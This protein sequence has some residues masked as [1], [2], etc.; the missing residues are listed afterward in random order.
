MCRIHRRQDRPLAS[1]PGTGVYCE[2]PAAPG[3]KPTD[4]D[5]AVDKATQANPT[6]HP[7]LIHDDKISRTFC[8]V[9]ALPHV[10]TAKGPARAFDA[11]VL[12]DENIHTVILRRQSSRLNCSIAEL[13]SHT[14]DK[15]A[16][17]PVFQGAF[18]VCSHIA[19]TPHR[20]TFQMRLCRLASE[21]A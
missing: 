14:D 15:E 6:V 18:G 12:T 8:Y 2:P 11:I 16:F 20:G 21:Q 17:T 7:H 10:S 9:Y 5:L 4:G 3:A 1:G 13:F 19:A